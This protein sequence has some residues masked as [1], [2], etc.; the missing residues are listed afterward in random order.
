MKQQEDDNVFRM[1]DLNPQNQQ[2]QHRQAPTNQEGTNP[3]S[4]A[5]AYLR[6]QLQR[7][8]ENSTSVKLLANLVDMQK[9]RIDE[10]EEVI[11]MILKR[12]E[13]RELHQ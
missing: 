11:E 6:V 8:D 10:L 3:A 12:Q 5:D 9:Q 4:F 7:I 1:S 13:D 2:R